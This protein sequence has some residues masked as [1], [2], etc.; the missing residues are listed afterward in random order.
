MHSWPGRQLG[1]LTSQVAP[2]VEHDPA[3]QL[4]PSQQS[5]C[6][7]QNP[8]AGEHAIAP[9]PPAPPPE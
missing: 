5:A 9:P 1:L 6:A 4:S 3:L 7:E 2:V 8:D